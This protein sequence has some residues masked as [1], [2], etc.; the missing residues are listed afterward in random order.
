MDEDGSKFRIQPEIGSFHH[1]RHWLKCA[2]APLFLFRLCCSEWEAYSVV[3]L[4]AP[5]A[6]LVGTVD[7]LMGQSHKAGDA[8][9]R[10]GAGLACSFQLLC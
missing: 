9:A 4:L 6:L 8:A 1:F 7:R 5:A 10:P 3:I 2:I